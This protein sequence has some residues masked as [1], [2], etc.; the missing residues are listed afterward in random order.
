MKAWE[1]LIEYVKIPTASC[2]ESETVP[3][4][5]EQLVLAEYLVKELQELGLKAEMDEYGYVYGEMPATKGYEDRPV[6][7]W[8]AHMDTVSDFADHQVQPVL[9]EHYDGSDLPL[10]DSGRVLTSA[11]FPHIRTLIG[12]TLITSDGTTILGAD[13]KAGIAEIMTM[14]EE[15]RKKGMPHGRIPVAFTPD[16]EIGCGADHFDVKRFGADYAYTMDGGAEGEIEYENFNAA[17]VKIKIRGVNVHPG[18]AKNVMVNAALVGTE[19]A[20]LLPAD[21]IPAM[22]EGY[23][24]FYHMTEFR[25]DVAEAELHYIIRDHDYSKLLQK[26]AV[27]EEKLALLNEKY[28][29]GTLEMIWKEQYRNMSEMIEDEMHLIINARM[30]AMQS[31][32][33]PVTKPIRGG[34]DGARLSF[35]GLPCP[36]LGTGG[37]AFHG[38]YEH[39]TVEGMDKTVK[40]MLCIMEMYTG[41]GNMDCSH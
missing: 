32:I 41:S 22:T 21:E 5:K 9:H 33:T 20:S 7:G 29:A 4:T 31:N 28:G 14:L 10:G 39:I 19:F 36:N 26:K 17:G 2:E 40:M 1:R 35:M 30:A 18:D 12:R 13:D 3:S 6:L 27:M 16:E 24:G 37:F 38:P 11:M 25:G 23:Q 15:I 8:I 34:T